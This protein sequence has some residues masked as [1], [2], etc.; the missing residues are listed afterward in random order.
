MISYGDTTLELTQLRNIGQE[1][2][3]KLQAVGIDTP[4]TLMNLG[5]KQAYFRLKTQ[6]PNCCLVHLYCLEGAIRNLD[7]NCLPE[8][9]KREL[10]EFS[11]TLK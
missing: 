5:A 4:E 7:Y 2:Q 9:T 6:F 10:K 1:M 3:R 8:D 11:D